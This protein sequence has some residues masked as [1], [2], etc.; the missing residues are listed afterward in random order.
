MYRASI[1]LMMV[2]LPLCS[3]L[4]EKRIDGAAWMPLLAKWFVFWAVGVRLFL[5]GVM[6]LARPQYTAHSIFHFESDDALPI[7]REL[8]I[9]NAAGGIVG[10]ASL[11]NPA[12]VLPISIWAV[13]FYGGA[14]A[15]HIFRRERSSS[16]TLAMATDFLAFVVL[17]AVVVWSLV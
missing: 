14:S 3:I 1:V 8:G 5:A 17:A 12:F 2:I 7:V 11:A 10:I 13:V 9:A 16:E 15:G 4:L 6:Q